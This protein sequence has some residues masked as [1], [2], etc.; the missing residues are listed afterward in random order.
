LWNKSCGFAGYE[1]I[2][3]MGDFSCGAQKCMTPM[4]DV[5][6]FLSILNLLLYRIFKIQR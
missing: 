4:T 6:Y 1:Y 2:Q 5:V 3:S